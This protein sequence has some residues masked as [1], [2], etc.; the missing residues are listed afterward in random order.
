MTVTQCSPT[1]RS[2]RNQGTSG[3]DRPFFDVTA[4]QEVRMNSTSLSPMENALALGVVPHQVALIVGQFVHRR[5]D[6]GVGAPR[7]TSRL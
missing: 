5:P 7:P 1:G 4:A 2:H 6:N 3:V